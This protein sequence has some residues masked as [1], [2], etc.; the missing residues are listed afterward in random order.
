MQLR[1]HLVAYDIRDAKRLR[2]VHRKLKGYGMPLQYSVFVCDITRAHRLELVTSL[3]D[4]I[5]HGVDCI[6]VIE[7]ADDDGRAFQ[8]LGPRPDLPAAGAMII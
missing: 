5:D 1:R 4:I 6:A 8:F 7:L 3:R 2:L